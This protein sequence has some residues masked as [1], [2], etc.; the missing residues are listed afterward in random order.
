MKFVLL[1]RRESIIDAMQGH[2]REWDEWMSVLKQKGIWIDAFPFGRGMIVAQ[3]EVTEYHHTH[4]DIS[5]FL[6]IEVESLDAAVHVAQES[7]HLKNGGQVEVREVMP[8]K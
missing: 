4:M 5:G 7:P 8:L 3:T 6:E 1:F 2:V